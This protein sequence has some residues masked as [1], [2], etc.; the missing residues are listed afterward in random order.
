MGIPSSVDL[1]SSDP[2]LMV[3]SFNTGH[4]SI[5]NMETRQRILTLES[6]VDT[7]MYPKKKKNHILLKINSDA[8]NV[9]F[10]VFSSSQSD[11]LL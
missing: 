4:T 3:A 1:V 7:S 5:F 2:S 10:S 11:D 9:F 6:G 8:I